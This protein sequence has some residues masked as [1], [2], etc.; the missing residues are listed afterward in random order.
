[1]GH[2]VNIARVIAAG[3]AAVVSLTLSSVVAGAT[4]C[5][6][7]IPNDSQPPPG[8][9][10]IGP[11]SLVTH[12]NGQL[13]TILPQDGIWRVDDTSMRADGS[14]VTKFVWWRRVVERTTLTVDGVLTAETTF[15]GELSITGRR[16]DGPA[17]A[18]T[19]RTQPEGVHVGSTI[20]FP[21]GGCWEV[22]GRAGE[23]SLTFTV[24]MLAPGS[25]MANVALPPPSPWI[26]W[27]VALLLTA[28][29]LA[30][31]RL[32]TAPRR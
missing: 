32:T 27:G 8:G 1:M 11:G 24:Y 15:A 5:P 9:G 3:F 17:P 6:V 10:S 14:I 22:I 28:S 21:V 18:A 16:L 26:P 30:I 12:G 31:G 4:A 23:D 25:V 2:R 13:W 19:A 7:T 29:V 20:T